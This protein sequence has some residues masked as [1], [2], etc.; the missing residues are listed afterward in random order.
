MLAITL[1][2][3]LLATGCAQSTPPSAA[4][5]SPFSQ[6]PSSFATTHPSDTLPGLSNF[7]KVSDRLYRGAQPTAEGFQT[8]EKMGIKT[9]INLRA[10]HDDRDLLAQTGLKYVRIPC[11][12]MFPNDES[13]AAVLKILADPAAGPV[14][15]H[16]K[17]GADRTG[18]MVAAYRMRFEHWPL[19]AATAELPAFGFHEIYLPIRLHLQFLKPTAPRF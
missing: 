10:D 7:A 8:L 6:P 15:I 5:E 4:A 2:A 13:I 16:C 18:M 3:C 9:V 12:A 19:S 14:F 1:I 11:D 17:H